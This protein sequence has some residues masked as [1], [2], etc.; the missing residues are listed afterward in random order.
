[1]SLLGRDSEV[2]KSV[3]KLQFK[4]RQSGQVKGRRRVSRWTERG[5]GREGMTPSLFII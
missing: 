2:S 4:E 3:A 1:M 5:G